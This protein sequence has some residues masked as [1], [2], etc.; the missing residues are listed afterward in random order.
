MDFALP[1]SVEE[2][3]RPNPYGNTIDVTLP[4]TAWEQ[5]HADAT[6][7]YRTGNEEHRLSR[8]R[9]S[10]DP[11][12]LPKRVQDPMGYLRSA[13]RAAKDALELPGDPI[14]FT[15]D[16]FAASALVGSPI[17][18]S[19]TGPFTAHSRV[20]VPAEARSVLEAWLLGRS[21]WDYVATGWLD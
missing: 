10:S 16:E 12:L 6:D 4:R 18:A 17:R 21:D 14:T 5:A 1:R 8:P 11:L 13:I 15:C 20:F 9:P 19:R 2:A 7:E 3:K